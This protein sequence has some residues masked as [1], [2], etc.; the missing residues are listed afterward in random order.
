MNFYS[1]TE[2]AGLGLRSY[3]DNV[4]ISRN[5]SLYNAGSIDIGNHVRI[6][7]FCVL[8]AGTGGIT[9]GSFVHVAV[10]ASMIGAGRI[11]LGDYA[12]LSGRVA[13]YSSNDDYSGEHLTNPMVPAEY[14]RVAVADVIVGRHA[15]IG[16][17]AIVLPGVTIGE[18]AAIGA[19]S[20]VRK[21]CEPFSIYAGVPARR[22]NTRNHRVREL[23]A[24]HQ[25]T[26]PRKGGSE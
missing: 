11:V 8:S 14:R 18:G 1:G 3:G 26:L 25:A 5:A 16:A 20:L 17:G 12:G 6:D 10:Y 9:I 22:V 13:V 4:L 2:L 15:L 19:L 7:D 21:D 23:E 24:L